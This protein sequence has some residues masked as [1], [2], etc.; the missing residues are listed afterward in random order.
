MQLS[1]SCAVLDQLPQT[2]LQALGFQELIYILRFNA[3]SGWLAG[4]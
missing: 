3:L 2:S 4:L 1:F